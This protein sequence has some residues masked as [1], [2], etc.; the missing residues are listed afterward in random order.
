MFQ[1]LQ[2]LHQAF[3]VLNLRNTPPL[4]I[5]F[6]Q[7]LNLIAN[8][9]NALSSENQS[10]F[11]DEQS[12]RMY[13]DLFDLYDTMTKRD[14]HNPE[15]QRLY[16]RYV[17][18][19]LETIQIAKTK[20]KEKRLVPLNNRLAAFK[21]WHKG[22]IY[23]SLQWGDNQDYSLAILQNETLILLCDE[24]EI[25]HLSSYHNNLSY[26][27]FQLYRQNLQEKYFDLIQKAYDNVKKARSK[28]ATL[29]RERL[30]VSVLKTHAKHIAHSKPELAIS[31]YE[32]AIEILKEME[33][34]PQQDQKFVQNTSFSIYQNLSQIYT[35]LASTQQSLETY[36]TATEYAAR[37]HHLSQKVY[38]QHFQ[39]SYRHYQE[40]THAYLVAL[41]SSKEC[42]NNEIKQGF[43]ALLQ[44]AIHSAEVGNFEPLAIICHT[45]A[46]MLFRCNQYDKAIK[47]FE[48][49]LK[50]ES[51][52]SP[53]PIIS[54]HTRH[55]L[56]AAYEKKAE[57]ISLDP[58][59]VDEAFGYYDRA[60][61]LS[62]E[63]E[64][65][66]A[67]ASGLFGKANLFGKHR[68]IN[69]ISESKM[70]DFLQTAIIYLIADFDYQAD[71][72]KEILH[73]LSE[74]DP[75]L[76]S[77]YENLN[78]LELTQQ[79]NTLIAMYHTIFNTKN[80]KP[81]LKRKFPKPIDSRPHTKHSKSQ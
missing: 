21:K 11:T 43:T 75:K 44:F 13:I 63:N 36:K 51:K 45:F 2:K 26:A 55:L 31:S 79:E 58:R 52:H 65:L 60:I 74:N 78:T 73:H 42:S 67:M 32:E 69:H 37:A 41:A 70:I 25:E 29:K 80:L 48:M 1:S 40:I 35:K 46:N 27:Y 66:R 34:D 61:R 6:E 5:N 72:E 47:Y 56:A 76:I 20:A 57:L 81:A 24:K 59:R 50:V 28:G 22:R 17:Q 18:K 38:E 54:F 64:E 3:E 30:H 33:K 8:Y 10:T 49:A 7:I 23:H 62:E 12:C 9:K 77:K 15:E 16:C 53:E 39:T 14:S 19:G 71:S 4:Q 68:S